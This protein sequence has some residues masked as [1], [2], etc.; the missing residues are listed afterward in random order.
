M[1]VIGPR[2][3]LVRDMVF[4]ND[5]REYVFRILAG[6]WCFLRIFR[7]LEVWEE[8]SVPELESLASSSLSFGP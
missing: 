4:M 5:R 7:D 3:Q 2:P 6:Q 1:S 8:E